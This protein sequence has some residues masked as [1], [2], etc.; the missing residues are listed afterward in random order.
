MCF[1]TV[2]L[3][4]LFTIGSVPAVICCASCEAKTRIQKVVSKR[5]WY[6]NED[7]G[8]RNEGV[9][10]VQ[11]GR[12]VPHLHLLETITSCVHTCTCKCTHIN[13]RRQMLISPPTHACIN[14]CTH[15]PG[16]RLFCSLCFKLLVLHCICQ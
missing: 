1:F 9:L 7:E 10:A 13:T 4:C 2:A 11:Q 8:M 15:K 14:T 12:F 5:R 6:G 16:E 3:W